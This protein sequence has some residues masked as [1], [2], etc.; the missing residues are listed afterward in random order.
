M[1]KKKIL[2]A[3]NSFKECASSTKVADLFEKFLNTN[4]NYEIFKY[5]I[6]D[7]G[8]GLLNVLNYNNKLIDITYSITT[9]Y[10]GSKFD[11][12]VGYDERN[13]I[14]Y[15]ESA[16]ALGLQMIPK[17]KRHPLNLSSKGLGELLEQVGKSV[18]NR[19]IDVNKVVIGVGGTGT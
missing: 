15:I 1:N 3:P 9:P 17:E 12:T 6:S 7:G 11:C 5:P 2:L 4:N 16:K 13:K 18:F 19:E 14:I 8:D 10:D